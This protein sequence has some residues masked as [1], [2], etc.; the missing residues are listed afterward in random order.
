M[1]TLKRSG[2][3]IV[4]AEIHAKQAK[5]KG[6]SKCRKALGAVGMGVVL[7][8]GSYVEWV[9]FFHEVSL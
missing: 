3:E 5:T 2:W 8:L 7:L 4:I 6:P 9:I 1:A